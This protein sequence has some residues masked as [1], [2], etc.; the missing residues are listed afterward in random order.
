MSYEYTEVSRIEN[1]HKYMYTPYQGSEFIDAYFRDR[2]Q[3]FESFARK[4]G[5]KYKN[6]IGL[7][8]HSR[9]TII[10]KNFL[11]SEFSDESDELLKAK[12]D[13][14][15]SPNL[16][17]SLNDD[18]NIVDLSSFDI[19]GRVNSED[20]LTSLLNSQLSRESEKTVKFWLEL[21]VQRFEVTK[22]IYESYPVNFRKGGGRNNI[23]RLYYLFALSLTLFY[24]S[25]KNIKYLSTLLKVTDLLCSLEE[26]LLNQNIPLQGL[27]TILLV[28]LLSI[29]SLSKTIDEVKFD[30][31]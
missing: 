4:S 10:L 19:S 13:W 20:L 12:V 14:E 7:L 11:D 23:V 17:Y 18:G 30:F 31:V 21:L 5:Q 1:P 27:A 6:S 28:E 3:Y 25:T 8:L 26:N 15:N 2:V 22:K 16:D 9:A 29:K 24:C